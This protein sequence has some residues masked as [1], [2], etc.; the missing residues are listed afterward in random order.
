MDTITNY[1]EAV[2][3]TIGQY[4][5]LHLS[6]GNI[7]LDTVFD[8]VQDR[9]ALIQVGW[10]NGRRVNGNLIYVTIYNGVIQLE[11][12]GI[13]HGIFN[14]LVKS[15]IPQEQIVLTDE[16]FD[17]QKELEAL[18]AEMKNHPFAKMSKEEVLAELRKTRERIAEED[19]GDLPCELV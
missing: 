6:D 10:D 8:E 12:D 19:Y 7:R 15:G 14:D 13:E 9:Y 5:K 17:W 4:A 1:R 18:R 3:K 11:Y 16:P 2:K